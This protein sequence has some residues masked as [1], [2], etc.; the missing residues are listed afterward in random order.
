MRGETILVQLENWVSLD[1]YW[2]PRPGKVLGRLPCPSQASLIAGSENKSHT[3]IVP[4]ISKPSLTSQ[5]RKTSW[6]EGGLGPR[7]F[8]ELGS[9]CTLGS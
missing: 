1:L 8:S 3:Q 2:S 5:L 7:H 4:G 9:L 6:M